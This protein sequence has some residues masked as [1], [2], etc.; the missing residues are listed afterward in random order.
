MEML[1]A[2]MHGFKFTLTTGRRGVTMKT[3]LSNIFIQLKKLSFV[4]ITD[5]YTY[6]AEVKNKKGRPKMIDEQYEQQH[7]P[8]PASI[9]F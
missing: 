3:P 4:K 1:V 2:L 8:K 7:S 9:L 6:N 5:T